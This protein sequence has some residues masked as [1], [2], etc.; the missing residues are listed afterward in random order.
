MTAAE[1]GENVKEKTLADANNDAKAQQIAAQEE[2]DNDIDRKTI[3]G[4]IV[5]IYDLLSDVVNGNKS[6]TVTTAGGN[7][8][9][10][11][12]RGGNY[13]DEIGNL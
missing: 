13:N 8:A 11:W 6:L 4:T 7:A 5:Q 3:N 10:G 12:Q 9:A 1:T 2:E